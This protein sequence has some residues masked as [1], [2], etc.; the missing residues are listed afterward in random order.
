MKDKKRI[1]LVA[2][3]KD[4]AVIGFKFEDDDDRGTGMYGSPLAAEERL[5]PPAKYFTPDLFKKP[6]KHY[7]E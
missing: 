7:F 6:G 3:V 5:T 4:G 1:P 2:I